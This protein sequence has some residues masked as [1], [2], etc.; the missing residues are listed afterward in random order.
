MKGPIPAGCDRPGLA[1][2]AYPKAVSLLPGAQFWAVLFFLMVILLGLDSQNG[3]VLFQLIDSYGPSG[4][5]L[6]FIACFECIAV[7]WITLVYDTLTSSSI[8]LNLDYVPGPWA[9]RVAC[10]LIL[11][12]LMCIPVYILLCLWR[13]PAGMTTPSS[14]LRQARPH[15]PRLTVCDHVIIKGQEKPPRIAGEQDEK[16]VMEESSGV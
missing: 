5:S 16:L 11:T 10:L 2:I 1:F 6:L 14:D 12:P 4:T 7:A 9:S 15:E 3:I 13:N 8:N